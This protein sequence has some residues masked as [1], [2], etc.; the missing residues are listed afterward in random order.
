MKEL[1]TIGREGAFCAILIM[2]SLFLNG[3]CSGSSSTDNAYWGG[4][5][6]GTVLVLGAADYDSTEG[7]SVAVSVSQGQSDISDAVVT[8][9]GT[10]L[11][12][13]LMLPNSQTRMPGYYGTTTGAPGTSLGLTVSRYG[14]VIYSSTVTIPETPLFTDP[15]A[16]SEFSAG[17]VLVGQWS[18][19]FNASG[20]L[21]DYMAQDDYYGAYTTGTNWAIPAAYLKTGTGEFGITAISGDPGFTEGSV[22]LS[23]D[24]LEETITNGQP[25]QDTDEITRSTWVALSGS[26]ITATGKGPGKSPLSA[27]K[28][29]EGLTVA[30][31]QHITQEGIRLKQLTYNPVQSAATGTI[32]FTLRFDKLT[33]AV[34]GFQLYDAAG[35]KKAEWSHKRIYERKRKKYTHNLAATQGDTLV[36][37]E[38]KVDIIWGPTFNY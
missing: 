11:S 15:A 37:F 28:G 7:T 26:R 25:A 6:A 13:G 27:G 30:T 18:A 38:R 4:S 22:Y 36:I 21:M 34:G 12:P 2:L 19:A 33:I 20:Y 32:T 23:H 5:D 31:I 1:R 14:S 8:V 16:G 29:A 9:N 17:Q 35:N 3:G 24:D 10:A